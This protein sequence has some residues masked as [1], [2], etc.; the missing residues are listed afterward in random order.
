MTPD[1]VNSWLRV[2]R[3]AVPRSMIDAVTEARRQGDWRAAC[4]AANV[5][6]EDVPDEF[7]EPG[8]APDLVRWHL[9]RVLGG[10]D[11]LV[12]RLWIVLVTRPEGELYLR[13][14]SR[15][16]GHQRLTLAFGTMEPE[17]QQSVLDW[18]DSRHLW[19]ADHADELRIRCGGGD[20]APFFHRDGT[21]AELPE[22]D[23]GTDDPAAYTEWLVVL[24]RR[25]QAEAAFRAVGKEL[26][27]TGIRRTWPW[28][29]PRAAEDL[30]ERP[31]I[32]TR[33]P[34]ERSSAQ[35]AGSTGL[36]LDGPIA[37]VLPVNDLRRIP[38]ANAYLLPDLELIRRG[39]LTPGELHPLVRESL[40]PE[41][42]GEI[43]EPQPLELSE[44]RVR[45][46]GEWHVVAMRDGV[47]RTPHTEAEHRRERALKAFGGQIS[48]CFEAQER[49]RDGK[50]PH[51]ALRLQRD[52]MFTRMRHGDT[53]AV[54]ALLDMGFD[55]FVRNG[56]KQ[57][58]L[59]VVHH[60][61]FEQVLPRLLKA[62]LDLEARDHEGRTPLH[63]AVG[64]GGS[65]ALVRALIE[66]GARTDA[67]DDLRRTLGTLIHWN[68]RTDLPFI[69]VG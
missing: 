34:R 63:V 31:L 44:V 26:D 15:V 65:A 3:H 41:W 14:P 51:K 39:K 62:G 47:L 19:H 16:D 1:E 24:Q 33:L 42:T 29:T 23:P 38:D 40:F 27:Q 46:Q 45:C 28:Y 13:T 52:A 59:H 53:A 9:P 25:G 49:L 55:P 56:R 58:L 36:L 11:S 37:R 48:G 5:D 8:F 64:D 4:A 32:L 50:R 69:D 30:A 20:R 6:I 67:T 18:T 66:A 22:T 68:K 57:T 2:R 7:A 12:P 17:R 35:L 10:R 43:P 60:V 61:D 54:L 21:P